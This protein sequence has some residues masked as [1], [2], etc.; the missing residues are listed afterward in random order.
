VPYSK[1]GALAVLEHG[2]DHAAA[3]AALRLAGY[4]DPLPPRATAVPSPAS[5]EGNWWS[6]IAGRHTLLDWEQLWADTPED[7]QWLVEPL[8]GVGRLI[9]LYSPP[10][11]GK[12]LLALE[13]AAAVATGRPVLSQ[14]AG[15]PRKVLYVDLENSRRDLRDRLD[16]LG[17]KPADLV[18]L[19]Y[20]SF[21]SLPALN[22]AAGGRELLALAIEHDAVLV[23]IDTVSRVVVGKENDADT[24]NDLYYHALAPLK[25][26]DVA[27]IRLDHAGKDLSKGQRGS[28]SKDGDVD[29]VWSLSS[30]GPAI[31]LRCERSRTLSEVQSISL[32]RRTGPLRHEMTGHGAT[33]DAVDKVQVMMAK[34]DEL[35]VPRGDGFIKA[36]RVLN[37]AAVPVDTNVLKQAIRT[38]RMQFDL[39]ENLSDDLGPDS[40]SSD[41][42]PP[43]AQTPDLSDDLQTGP[44][45]PAGQTSL[46]DHQTGSDRSVAGVSVPNLSEAGA[47]LKEAPRRQVQAAPAQTAI[48]TRCGERG[49][50]ASNCPAPGPVTP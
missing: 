24:F 14:P 7:E 1:F 28:S 50:P 23:I 10:K 4:G 35:G 42:F 37:Q 49:H 9:A 25:G 33:P 44:R 16:A 38:R 26:R 5:S 15:E 36:S 32:R 18:R 29:Q 3:A 34:L 27:V 12:S 20:L 41:R 43:P 17:Y 21:P 19:A 11:A 45:E 46:K 40:R 48:C 30:A 31:T 2:G 47:S 6:E 13:I 39:S 22:S 8:I